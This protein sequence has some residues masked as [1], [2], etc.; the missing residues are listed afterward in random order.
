MTLLEK[1]NISYELA[2]KLNNEGIH[3]HSA[4]HSYYAILQMMM[5]VLFFYNGEDNESLRKKGMED[6]MGSHNVIINLFLSLG[7]TMSDQ[8]K[9]REVFFRLKKRRE[10]ADYFE[11]NLTPQNCSGS[12]FNSKEIRQLI[13]NS[14][15]EFC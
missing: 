12:L 10:K 1:S 13:L 11:E 9:I 14:Y 6:K 15:G 5:H 2:V 3:N 7:P 4:H 8:R